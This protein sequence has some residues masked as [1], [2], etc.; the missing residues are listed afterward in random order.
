MSQAIASSFACLF[1]YIL[2]LPSGALS[3][4]FFFYIHFFYLR[5]TIVTTT[6]ATII[7]FSFFPSSLFHASMCCM[8]FLL[9]VCSIFDLVCMTGCPSYQ[10]PLYKLWWVHF[11]CSC[12]FLENQKSPLS[13]LLALFIGFIISLFSMFPFF[14]TEWEEERMIRKDQCDKS[15]EVIEE[16]VR[17]RTR[18]C[19]VE[20]RK[21]GRQLLEDC[22]WGDWPTSVWPKE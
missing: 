19:A 8:C 3:F 14:I 4:L 1:I 22:W 20:E 13:P 15:R 9:L 12:L 7:V 16:N 10:Q 5:S 18:V 2:Q 17:K 11:H 6:T 21:R